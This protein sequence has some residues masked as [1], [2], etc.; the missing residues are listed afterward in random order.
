MA[1]GNTLLI[2]TALH[3]AFPAASYATIDMRNY[4]PCLDFDDSS[5][6]NAV[7][8][9][10]MPQA[11][12][13]NGVTVYLHYAMSTATSGD[14]IWNVAF[15]RIGD[16][17]QDI[18][19]D[20]FAAAQTSGAVTVP[21]TSGLIDVCSVAFTHGAQ[22]DSIE[23]GDGFRIKVTRDADN[24]DDDAEGDAELLF[25]ELRET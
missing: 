22:I 13:G 16:Q 25:I 9:A 5:D 10:I 2:F 12:N 11:Y 3:A 21:G 17:Q 19:S 6:E 14:V 24:E 7:F 8:S 4:H 23:S 20:S 15:E 1:S 18:D